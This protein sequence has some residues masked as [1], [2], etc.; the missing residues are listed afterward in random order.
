MEEQEI[1]PR[2]QA[3]H[4]ALIADTF[5]RIVVYARGVNPGLDSSER[6]YKIDLVLVARGGIAR[7]LTINKQ[8]NW[9]AG[10]QAITQ[11]PDPSPRDQHQASTL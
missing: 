5:E 6:N 3:R 8:G 1:G 7:I 9:V 4:I 2:Q 10:E 11:A